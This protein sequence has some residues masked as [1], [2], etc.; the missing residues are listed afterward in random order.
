MSTSASQHDGDPPATSSSPARALLVV[1]TRPEAIKMAPVYRALERSPRIKPILVSTGQHR[2]LLSQ[3]LTALDLE[4]THELAVMVPDQDPSQVMARV[5]ERI[6]NVLRDTQP[7]LVLVQG[8]TTSA[9]AAALAAYHDHIPVGH[10]EAG[11]RTYDLANP[12]PEEGNRQLVDRLATWC[13]APTPLARD[14]LLAERIAAERIRVT[15]NTAVDS[16]LWAA[17]RSTSRLEPN[18]LLLTLHR[19]ESFGEALEQILLGVRDFLDA[20]PS[21]RAVW[22]VHPN[23]NVVSVAERVL[24]AHPRVERRAPIDYVSFAGML[25]SCRLVLTDSGGIQEEAPSL[26]KTVLVARDMT[27]RPEGIS[28]ARNQIVGRTRSGIA[29]ALRE[30]W[31]DEPYRGS[32]P[33]P[34]PYGDGKAGERIAAIVEASI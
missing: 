11:L 1:G 23:P 20:N 34:N 24:G 4:A 17:E 21:A 12:F 18:T 15:G 5:L 16:L 10:I 28:A 29:H 32:L 6:P 30:A 25:A 13:F 8:D 19:R 27:E 9:L 31:H 14:N 2:E 26:G 33:A 7:C 22:P 3:T